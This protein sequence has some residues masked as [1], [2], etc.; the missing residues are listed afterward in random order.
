MLFKWI[1]AG[2]VRTLAIFFIYIQINNNFFIFNLLFDISFNYLKIFLL[3]YIYNFDS[4]I[5]VWTL[6]ISIV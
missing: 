6:A 5:L 2:L 4:L 1:R 3:K